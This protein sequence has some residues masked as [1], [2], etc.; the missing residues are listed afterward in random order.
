[1]NMILLLLTN[2][3][4]VPPEELMPII[5]SEESEEIRERI[6]REKEREIRRRKKVITSSE[7]LSVPQELTKLTAFFK[8]ILDGELRKLEM[9]GVEEEEMKINLEDMLLSHAERNGAILTKRDVALGFMQTLI[10][11]NENVIEVEQQEYFGDIYLLKGS[12]F[13]R[14]I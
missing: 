14:Q 13:Y 12:D 10:L 9:E 8:N 6:R 2:I 7:E 3:N 4:S 1:M 5:I 11:K